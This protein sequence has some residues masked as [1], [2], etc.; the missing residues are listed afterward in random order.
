MVVSRTVRQALGQ[1]VY[2]NISG[3]ACA[4]PGVYASGGER[5]SR[6]NF[7][8]EYVVGVAGDWRGFMAY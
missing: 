6:K 2:E 3:K 7:W 5:C 8:G 4:L 1:H